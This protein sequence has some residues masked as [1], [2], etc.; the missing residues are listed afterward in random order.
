MYEGDL[1]TCA[2]LIL[3]WRS[4]WG[5]SN[6]SRTQN[7][8]RLSGAYVTCIY[9][10]LSMKINTRRNAAWLAKIVDTFVFCVCGWQKPKYPQF[11]PHG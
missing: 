9:C 4:N 3:A 1:R 8:R 7:N 11:E 6:I 5:Y 10:G 2:I